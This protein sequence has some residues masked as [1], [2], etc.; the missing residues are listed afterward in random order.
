VGDGDTAFGGG[1]ADQY[2]VSLTAV[3]PDPDGLA[4]DRAWVRAIWDD[5]LPLATGPGSY[6]NF[7]AEY[8]A[9]RVRASYGAS[10]YQRLA[11]I[12]RQYDPANVFHRNANIKPV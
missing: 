12:K 9:D 8:E 11:R 4:A 3:C 1:R 6:V 2:A 5:L 7:M 10:K